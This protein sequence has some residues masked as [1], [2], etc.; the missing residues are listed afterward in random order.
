MTVTAPLPPLSPLA[1]IARS[2][3]LSPLKLAAPPLGPQTGAVP[4]DAVVAAPMVPTWVDTARPTAASH[5]IRRRAL[6]FPPVI[7]V[8]SDPFRSFRRTLQQRSCAHG[9]ARGI[10]ETRKDPRSAARGRDAI[11]N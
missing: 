3:K 4:A 7:L 11:E 10:R 1:P 2:P 9:A 5:P 6:R 8:I